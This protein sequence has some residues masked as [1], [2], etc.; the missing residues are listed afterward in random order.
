MIIKFFFSIKCPLVIII[1]MLLVI[2][3]D[4]Q[5]YIFF[6][7]FSWL[8]M[9]CADIWNALAP[10]IWLT[11]PQKNLLPFPIKYSR[12][13]TR[14]EEEIAIFTRSGFLYHTLSSSC[15]PFPAYINVELP[16]QLLHCA[17]FL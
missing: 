2:D 15:Y 14:K 9:N 11:M 8:N 6:T 3:Y 5:V 16:L 1:I 12:L 4:D 13:W 10:F 17:F 7:C